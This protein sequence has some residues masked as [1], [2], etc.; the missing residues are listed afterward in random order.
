MGRYFC[1][2]PRASKDNNINA[3]LTL[4]RFSLAEFLAD[5]QQ[6]NPFPRW[7]SSLTSKSFGGERG[8]F[9]FLPAREYIDF[10]R[11][12]WKVHRIHWGYM[13]V[14]TSVS[15]RFPLSRT[16]IR[17]LCVCFETRVIRHW[18]GKTKI[19]LASWYCIGREICNA[20]EVCQNYIEKQF[21]NRQIGT[22]VLFSSCF[23]FEQ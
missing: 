17:S 14:S 20:L 3:G 16:V 15:F 6:K 21:A 2:P 23:R 13:C 1:I 4:T 5:R 9:R 12:L 10:S 19:L 11:I 22:H 18:R 7:K 8:F